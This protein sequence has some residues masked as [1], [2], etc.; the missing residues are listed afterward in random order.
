LPDDEFQA[1]LDAGV[2][3]F[4]YTPPDTSP[5]GTPTVDDIPED[6]YSDFQRYYQGIDSEERG[7]L[8]QELEGYIERNVDIGGILASA[9]A[10]D[11]EF[12]GGYGGSF[13][14]EFYNPGIGFAGY[15]TPQATGIN[16]RN[17]FGQYTLSEAES[18]RDPVAPVEMP[19]FSQTQFRSLNPVEQDALI[20]DAVS[21]AGI[22]NPSIPEAMLNFGVLPGQVASAI[23]A[24]LADLPSGLQ[25]ITG[26]QFASRTIPGVTPST[27]IPQVGEINSL[28][29]VSTGLPSLGV[30]PL[31][32]YNPISFAA[33]PEQVAAATIGAM[34]AAEAEQ[35]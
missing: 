33:T 16:V 26:D 32:T 35:S 2:V 23:G 3:P 22:N 20:R 28:S 27:F 9:G 15:R 18:Q 19:T 11:Y 14:P 24:P 31:P 25:S 6:F 13:E 12:G 4:G 21:S 29:G 30:Q 17:P 5:P 7:S 8:A 1:Y 10:Q 34:N